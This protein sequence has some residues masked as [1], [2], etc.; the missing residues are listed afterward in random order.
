MSFV[1]TQLGKTYKND[2]FLSEY[3]TKSV[4]TAFRCEIFMYSIT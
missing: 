1:S 4:V 2:P 3:Y